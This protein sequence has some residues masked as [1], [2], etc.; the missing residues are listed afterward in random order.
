MNA[1]A[2]KLFTEG[3]IR[4]T[5]SKLSFREGGNRKHSSRSAADLV[6]TSMSVP[7]LSLAGELSGEYGLLHSSD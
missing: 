4:I 6:V 2:E 7:D 5:N 3:I 1:Q